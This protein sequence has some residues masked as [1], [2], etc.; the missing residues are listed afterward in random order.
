VQ[1]L[2]SAADV[3]VPA[4]ASQQIAGAADPPGLPSPVEASAPGQYSTGADD[5]HTYSPVL[6]VTGRYRNAAALGTSAVPG[7]PVAAYAQGAQQQPAAWQQQAAL[8]APWRAC[9]A[10]TPASWQQQAVHLLRAATWRAFSTTSSNTSSS[11]SPA[12]KSGRQPERGLAAGGYQVSDFPPERIRNFC[13]IA[14]IDHGKS[15]LAGE[16]L[17]GRP[18]SQGGCSWRPAGAYGCQHGAQMA[19]H[20]S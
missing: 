5:A 13:I 10:V 19:A 16:P 14:H 12:D 11:S 17:G 1:C 18:G 8:S 3:R 6:P 20:H 4:P 9:G 15:T 7:A 2:V